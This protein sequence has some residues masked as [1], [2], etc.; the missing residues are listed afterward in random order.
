MSTAAAYTPA[1]VAYCGYAE[2]HRGSI[3]TFSGRIQLDLLDL[4]DGKCRVFMEAV[5]CQDENCFCGPG[6]CG[7]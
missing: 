7:R 2:N 3:V 6:R 4:P 1:R 5:V